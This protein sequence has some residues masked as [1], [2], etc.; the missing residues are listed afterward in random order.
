MELEPANSQGGRQAVVWDCADS[1]S[2]T[3]TAS[4]SGTAADPVF[5]VSD[6]DPLTFPP[7]DGK[8]PSHHERDSKLY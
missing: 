8:L 1:S 3:P 2:G 5:T 4:H 6:L 7:I